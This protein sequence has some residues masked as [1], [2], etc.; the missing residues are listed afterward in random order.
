MNAYS[1]DLRKKIVNAVE[2]RGT[3]QSDIARL[4][5]VSLSSAK[6]YVRKFRQGKSLSPG[7]APGKRPIIDEPARSLLE[8]HLKERP[9][10]T[11]RERCEYLRTVVG[12]EIQP[13]RGVPPP[14]ADGFHQKKGTVTASEK[15]EWIRTA[16]RVT[17]SEV[18]EPNRLVFVDE[19]GLHTSLGG[20][21]AGRNPVDRGKLGIKRSTVV[22]ARASRSEL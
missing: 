12:L 16:W 3:G 9:F 14:K 6:R 11:L 4:F 15:D 13:I 2:Q 21:K 20:E 17:V 8:G 7:K 19:M 18:V 1:E 22:D 10:V 5:D